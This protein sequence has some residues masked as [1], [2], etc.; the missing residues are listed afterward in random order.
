M[1]LKLFILL[2]CI[3]TLSAT[4]Y[5]QDQKLDVKFENE[6]IV[7]VLDYLKM[8]TGYQFFFQ[9]GIVSETEK[10]TVVLKNATLNEVL[11]KVLKD[12]G[13]SYEVLDG[14]IVVRRMEEQKQEKKTLVG[15]VT[16]QKKVPMP[17]VTVKIFGTN[18]GTATNAK[19]QFSLTLPMAQGALEFS[20]VG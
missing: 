9:K 1:K 13:Y 15:I 10:I 2:C 19:G 20:F 16:D 18:I 14:V 17:G 12:H 3:H 8:Q 5:S 4:T 11:D 7:S 6:L